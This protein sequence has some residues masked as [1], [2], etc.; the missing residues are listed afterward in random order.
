MDGGTI[1]TVIIIGV[2]LFLPVVLHRKDPGRGSH[3]K[4]GHGRSG[5]CH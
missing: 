1:F 5:S 4:N 3:K 2:F